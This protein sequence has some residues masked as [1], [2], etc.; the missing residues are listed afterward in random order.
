[1]Y[2]ISLWN[3]FGGE[4]LEEGQAEDTEKLIQKGGV[5]L[6]LRKMQCIEK[7]KL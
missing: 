2:L 1:M 7:K 4:K 5:S 3:T 6:V